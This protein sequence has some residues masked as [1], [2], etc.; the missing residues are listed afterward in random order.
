MNF[1]DDVPTLPT[2]PVK[3]KAAPQPPVN[4]GIK[5]DEGK[6]R[7]DLVPPKSLRELADVLTFGAEKYAPNNWKNVPN[8]SDRYY[9]ALLR[10]LEAWREGEIMDSESGKKHLAHALCCLVFLNES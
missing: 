10:H 3:S 2:S 4:P 8:P 9:S 6:I 7:Y 5:Y 1:D